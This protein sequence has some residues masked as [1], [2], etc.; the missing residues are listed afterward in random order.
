MVRSVNP[1]TRRFYKQ[2]SIR[3]N[4]FWARRCA[5][6]NWGAKAIYAAGRYICSPVLGAILPKKIYQRGYNAD[7]VRVYHLVSLMLENHRSRDVTAPHLSLMGIFEKTQTHPE[8]FGR[9]KRIPDPMELPIRGQKNRL[10]PLTQQLLDRL[11]ADGKQAAAA[12]EQR[13][14]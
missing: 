9:V 6:G 2:A 7:F 4:V 3:W 10:L 13:R 1:A 8:D 12:L 11:K 14:K 5:Y